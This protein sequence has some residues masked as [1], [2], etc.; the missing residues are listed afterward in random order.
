MEMEG[1]CRSSIHESLLM[2][3]GEE[4]KGRVGRKRGDVRVPSL[5][6]PPRRQDSSPKGRAPSSRL[7]DGLGP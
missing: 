6:P 5:R 3:H 1:R 2:L 4:G 7:F